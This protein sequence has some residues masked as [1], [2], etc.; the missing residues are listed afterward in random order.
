MRSRSLRLT[1]AVTDVLSG[2]GREPRAML[3]FG[4]L[5][6]RWD[7]LVG[8]ALAAQVRPQSL[9]HGVLRLAC[10]SNAWM[11]AL[12]FQRAA[13]LERLAH[14]FPEVKLHEIRPVLARGHLTA[15]PG[16]TLAAAWPDWQAAAGED[17]PPGG[18]GELRDLVTRARAKC[19]A[20][21]QGLQAAGRVPCPRCG[22]CLVPAAAVCCAACREQEQQRRRGALIDLLESSPWL[23]AT[24]VV[25]ALAD[26]SAEELAAMR[27]E[28][29]GQW[30]ERL[31][32]DL[33]RLDEPEAD[34]T[35]RQ[36]LRFQICRLL[37]LRSQLPPDRLDLA[38]PRWDDELALGWRRA[39]APA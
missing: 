34:E 39:F 12:H 19:R 7:G 8:P 3:A 4:R 13:L 21:L 30:S 1:A 37:M 38:D 9:R 20:R 2:L 33:L 25:A 10:S 22:G 28:L 5:L 6:G 31:H 27:A 18:G 23:D 16:T 17:L 26:T 32:D 36:A 29:D 11:Q 35:L 14:E 24:A 15:R